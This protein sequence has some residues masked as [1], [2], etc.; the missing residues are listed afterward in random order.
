MILA[1]L[2]FYKTCRTYNYGNFKLFYRTQ[3]VHQ[4]VTNLEYF[5]SS[6]SSSNI[7]LS[8]HLFQNKQKSVWKIPTPISFVFF[9]LKLI[10][11]IV[12]DL[13]C[14]PATLTFFVYQ[15]INYLIIMTLLMLLPFWEISTFLETFNGANKMKLQT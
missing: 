14:S 8:L 10:I 5:L 3:Y 11:F 12:Q 9:V 1:S 4:I 13:N 6:C 2:D 15:I 7:I